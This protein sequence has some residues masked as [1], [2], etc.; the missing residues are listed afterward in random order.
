MAEQGAG[1]GGGDQEPGRQTRTQ[2]HRGAHADRSAALA[3]GGGR[4]RRP[5]F[6]AGPVLGLCAVALLIGAYAWLGRPHKAKPP[7]DL[8]MPASLAQ[9][10]GVEFRSG[11]RTLT[12]YRETGGKTGLGLRWAIGTVRGTS[13]DSA[14]INSFVTSLLELQPVRL[15]AKRPTATQLAQWGLDPPQASAS[16]LLLGNRPAMELLVGKVSPVGD[17]YASIAGRTAVY[18]I[19]TT[20]AGEV[21]PNPARWLPTSSQT[22]SGGSTASSSKSNANRSGPGAATAG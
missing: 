3:D 4:R 12:L 7:A 21:S 22:S 11:A 14:T 18:L 20:L 13:A 6:W 8:L 15:V 5:D 10:A 9:V 19:N 16:L 1:T 17:N 2:G